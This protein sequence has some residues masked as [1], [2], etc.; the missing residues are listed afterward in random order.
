M[1]NRK[2]LI[3]PNPISNILLYTSRISSNIHVGRKL[4]IISTCP[5][6]F[7]LLVYTKGL[8]MY[9]LYAIVMCKITEKV[10]CTLS[11]RYDYVRLYITQKGIYHFDSGLQS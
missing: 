5:V 11:Y 3:Q 8:Y 9:L 6:Q 2:H 1:F 4:E 7:L 10:L